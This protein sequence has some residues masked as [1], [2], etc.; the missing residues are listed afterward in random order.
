[1]LWFV[2][3]L[4]NIFPR[5]YTHEFGI[6]QDAKGTVELIKQIKLSTQQY[7]QIWWQQFLYQSDQVLKKMYQ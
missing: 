2:S 6:I 4:T 5:L 3:L 7:T 1:M